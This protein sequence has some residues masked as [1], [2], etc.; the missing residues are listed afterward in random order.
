MKRLL[1]LLCL[2]RLSM[3]QATTDAEA[4]TLLAAPVTNAVREYGGVTATLAERHCFGDVCLPAGATV[5]TKITGKIV[6]LTKANS[7]EEFVAF[8][9]RFTAH[10]EFWVSD[11]RVAEGTLAAPL[12]IDGFQVTGPVVVRMG[13]KPGL[14]E[15]TLAQP[16]TFHGWSVPAGFRL[17]MRVPGEWGAEATEAAEP[18]A[19]MVRQKKEAEA[20]SRA[21]VV[22]EAHLWRE[23][24]LVEPLRV[25]A[26]T[27]GPGSWAVTFMP[28]GQRLYSGT[29][30]S[31]VEA[32][33]LQVGP[34][35]FV[36]WC[37]RDGLQEAQ[38]AEAPPFGPADDPAAPFTIEGF[39]FSAAQVRVLHAG[40][41]VEGYKAETC[42]RGALTGY[43]LEL[44]GLSCFCGGAGIDRTRPHLEL[45]AKGRVTSSSRTLR[46][47]VEAAHAP[48]RCAPI[49]PGVP[50][51]P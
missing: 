37:D 33:V 21:R 36:Y 41:A 25:G 32:G 1:P 20:P 3:A 39:S 26:L 31:P 48:C 24:E 4:S 11:G 8:G 6:T 44:G 49:P 42:T 30:A 5:S 40:K 47:E 19:V 22:R 28:D 43:E 51:P 46:Q 34:G 15:G 14:L 13:R 16:A 35:A 18:T 17:S 7:P 23:V 29:L 9:A 12:S 45:D 50:P 2:A 38:G 10:S 27:F